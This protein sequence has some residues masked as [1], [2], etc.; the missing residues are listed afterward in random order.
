MPTNNRS[1]LQVSL[2]PQGTQSRRLAIAA[3]GAVAVFTLSLAFSF[4]VRVALAEDVTPVQPAEAPAG[5]APRSALPLRAQPARPLEADLIC[6]AQI[7]TA[8]PSAA[9]IRQRFRMPLMLLRR[10]IS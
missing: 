5:S 10:A 2:N 1:H 4:S 9:P 8:R 7:G 3:L 6:F